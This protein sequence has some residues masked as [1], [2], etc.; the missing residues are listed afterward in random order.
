MCVGFSYSPQSLT[1]VSSWGFVRLPPSCNSNYLGYIICSGG[2]Y[3]LMRITVA[4]RAGAL[5][6]ATNG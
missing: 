5:T 4:R 1:C 2:G 6:E 3:F